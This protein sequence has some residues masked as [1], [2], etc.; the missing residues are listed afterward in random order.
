[1]NKPTLDPNRRDY[2]RHDW[3]EA[4]RYIRWLRS[5]KPKQYKTIQNRF[6][7]ESQ[8]CL[9]QTCF[10]FPS[11]LGVYAALVYDGTWKYGVS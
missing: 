6:Y 4:Y 9:T 10:L 11:L 7:G 2:T 5:G 8:V 1:M 3:R